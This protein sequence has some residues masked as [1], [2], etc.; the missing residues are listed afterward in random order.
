MGSAA[1]RDRVDP[2]IQQTIGLISVWRLRPNETVEAVVTAPMLNTEMSRP[3]SSKPPHRE[4]PLNGR[5]SEHGGADAERRGEFFRF[6]FTAR[7]AAIDPHSSSIGGGYASGTI[8]RWT[9]QQHRRTNS[10]FSPSI[11]ATGVQSSDRHY[12]ADFAE[13]VRP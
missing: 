5:N 4:L 13:P 10:H 2:Q 9:A 6:G 1:L 12:S 8:S 7:R 11:D 3:R